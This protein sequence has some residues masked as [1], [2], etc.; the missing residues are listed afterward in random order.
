MNEITHLIVAGHDRDC[1]EGDLL[2]WVNLKGALGDVPVCNDTSSNK[3]WAVSSGSPLWSDG[4]GEVSLCAPPPPF[5]AFFLSSILL[6]EVLFT[7][8]PGTYT[9]LTKDLDITIGAKAHQ[10]FT[11]PKVE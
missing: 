11:R 8:D 2:Y 5:V 1:M 7:Y 6:T 9:Y 3:T 4:V 10:S